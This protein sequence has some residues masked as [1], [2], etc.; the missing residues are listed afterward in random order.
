LTWWE[1]KRGK[2]AEKRTVFSA[3]TREKRLLFLTGR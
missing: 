3:K 1:K 2:N